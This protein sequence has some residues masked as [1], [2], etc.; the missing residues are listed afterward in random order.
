MTG[1]Q[2]ARH[3]VQEPVAQFHQASAIAVSATKYRQ[4]CVIL[5]IWRCILDGL[6]SLQLTEVQHKP[7]AYMPR[8]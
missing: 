3:A 7:G 8:L 1:V 5:S 2:S 4:Q 6:C